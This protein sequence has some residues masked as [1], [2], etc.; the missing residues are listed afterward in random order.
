MH[1]NLLLAINFIIISGCIHQQQPS[2]VL[3][4]GD[5][6]KSVESGVIYIN[7]Q[8]N[9]D[10]ILQAPLSSTDWTGDTRP[11][12]IAE[13]AQE[14]VDTALDA[15]LLYE[16]GRQFMEG[17]GVPKSQELAEHY[18]TLSAEM[19][20]VEA[21]RVLAILALRKNPDDETARLSLAH[22]AEVSIRAKA[23]YG[24]MLSNLAVPHLSNHKLGLIYL[25][26]A[27]F[28]GSDEAAY[29]LYLAHK[30]DS[31][32]ALSYLMTASER[33]NKHAIKIM[34]N[35]NAYAGKAS[36]SLKWLN[37]AIASGDTQAMHDYA[38]GLMIMRYK[39]SLTG[40]SLNREYEA[41]YWYNVAMN[42]GNVESAK[43]INNLK[44]IKHLMEK[45]GVTLAVLGEILKAP[46]LQ[47]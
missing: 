5:P 17:D 12:D 33:G 25:E 40:Y 31:E 22:A 1:K 7:D 9:N 16:M 42:M 27:Y 4:E 15:D 45:E 11:R 29:A 19:G 28:H 10:E 35:K 18:L 38:N 13:S 2:P 21:Q 26:D 47:E 24:M 36:D 3:T 39:P 6:Y 30:G 14:H 34:A 44:G 41:Y 43:E 46:Q 20:N 8:Q 23:Q 32:K 37:A